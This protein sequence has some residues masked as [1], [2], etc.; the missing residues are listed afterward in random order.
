M[1]RWDRACQ[2][3]EENETGGDRWHDQRERREGFDDGFSEPVFPG[4][5][6]GEKCGEWQ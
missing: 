4:E 6:P 5:Q 2:E 1:S 3:F